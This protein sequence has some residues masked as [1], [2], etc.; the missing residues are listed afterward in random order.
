MRVIIVQE[1][2]SVKIEERPIPKPAPHE[3]LLKII[4]A[5]ANPSDYMHVDDHSTPGDW[6]GTDFVGEVVELGPAVP[7]DRV[8]LGE[9]RWNFCRGGVNDKGAYADYITTSWDL[10]SV[11]PPN[12]TSQQAATLPLTLM[13]AVQAFYLP[14]CLALPEPPV[15]TPSQKWILIWS[16]ATAVGSFAIQLAKLSGFKVATTASPKRW[17]LLKSYGAD[18]VVDYRDQD[19]VKKLKDATGDAIEYGLDCITQGDSVRQTQLAFRPEGGHLI[20][21][22]RVPLGLPRPD[23]KTEFTFVYTSLGDQTLGPDFFKTAPSHRELHVRWAENTT[24]LLAD[25]KLKPLPV[26]VFGGLENVQKGLDLLR[27]KKHEGK[28][29]YNV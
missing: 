23:V 21:T 27:A 22:L 12:V 8:K 16:G 7:K 14:T 29:V 20:T 18:V 10:S 15:Q 13:T 25:G 17:E 9:I 5:G 6:L 1:D 3:I 24:Q 19:V 2:K 11:V 26:H 28:L 4:C